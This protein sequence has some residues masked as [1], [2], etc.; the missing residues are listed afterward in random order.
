MAKGKAQPRE[1]RLGAPS[2]PRL[3]NVAD[4]RDRILRAAISQFSQHGF[5]GARIEA[6]CADAGV[7]GVTG[8]ANDR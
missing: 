5:S 7:N 1:K 2:G 8:R 3:V 6:I 4:T